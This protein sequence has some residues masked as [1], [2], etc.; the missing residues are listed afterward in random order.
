[1][2]V[3]SRGTSLRC[4]STSS[5]GTRIAPGSFVVASPH[6]CGLRV[7][8]NVNISPR[9]IRSLTSST[10]T[11]VASIAPSLIDISTQLLRLR[12]AKNDVYL[13]AALTVRQSHQTT[14]SILRAAPLCETY[15]AHLPVVD[16]RR[17]RVRLRRSDRSLQRS[18]NLPSKLPTARDPFAHSASTAKALR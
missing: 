3:R 4:C 11:L 2:T 15:L 17:D 7:S 10:V 1:M 16:A 9:S 6:A 5:A 14:L 8:T 13:T 12:R 18:A